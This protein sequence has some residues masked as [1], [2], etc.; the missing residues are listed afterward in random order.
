MVAGFI[1][2][3]GLNMNGII[4]FLFLILFLSFSSQ[5]NEIQSCYD[6]KV[7]AY[8]QNCM[9]LLYR[10]EAE[11]YNNIYHD[12]IKNIRR[13][14][15]ANYDEFITSINES[16]LYWEKYI[17]GECKAEGLL[18]IKDSPAYSIA[19]NECMVKAYKERVAF[20]NKY[21]F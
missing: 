13:D 5:A 2:I 9:E 15:L 3:N 16:K 14:D 20:Y 17:V 4:S 8:I 6:K 7:T 19:Y 18:N 12:F 1:Y 11:E 21:P 10:Q